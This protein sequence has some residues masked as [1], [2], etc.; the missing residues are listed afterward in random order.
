MK[1]DPFEERLQSQPPRT[2]PPEWREHILCAVEVC[3]RPATFREWILQLLWPS[4]V[5][6][7]GLAA[8]WL[9]TIS[10]KLATPPTSQ[11][12]ARIPAPAA[13]QLFMTLG[14]QNR[15]LAELINTPPAPSLPARTTQFVP[16]PRS[17]GRSRFICV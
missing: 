8:V 13:A 4:P 12:L 17:E 6:W 10:F 14:E 2:I 5:A 16:R 11:S 3:A 9:L 15:I 7:A 1:P